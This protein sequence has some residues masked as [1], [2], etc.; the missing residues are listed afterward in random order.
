MVRWNGF[1]NMEH[2]LEKGYT[3]KD[4]IISARLWLCVNGTVEIAYI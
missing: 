3:D 4:E 1:T 2:P